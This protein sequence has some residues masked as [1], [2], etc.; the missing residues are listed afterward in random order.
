MIFKAGPALG[1]GL[2]QRPREGSKP[3]TRPGL[4]APAG[5]YCRYPCTLPAPTC[6]YCRYP[7]TLPYSFW[8]VYQ[9]AR[10]SS[11]HKK[12]AGWCQ[13]FLV[14]LRSARKGKMHTITSLWMSCM[15]QPSFVGPCTGYATSP[16]QARV[17]NADPPTGQLLPSCGELHSVSGLGSLQGKSS[18]P[19]EGLSACRGRSKPKKGCAGNRGCPVHGFA[20]P[21]QECEE[22]KRPLRGQLCWGS[23]PWRLH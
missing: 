2:G 1:Q 5:R 8:D 16:A 21:H 17:G 12:V 22:S 13:H 10:E 7:C 23:S 9:H 6:R 18:Q 11:T 3:I 14:S 15:A 20:S 4:P 19:P